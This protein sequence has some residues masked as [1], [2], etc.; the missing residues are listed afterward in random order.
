MGRFCNLPSV[1]FALKVG[2]LDVLTKNVHFGKENLPKV[3]KDTEN[4][5]GKPIPVT[6]AT[7]V[8]GSYSEWIPELPLSVLRTFTHPHGKLREGSLDGDYS[9]TR[10]FNEVL[11]ASM[12]DNDFSD[13]PLFDKVYRNFVP[14][15]QRVRTD[16][17][18]AGNNEGQIGRQRKEL[19]GRLKPTEEI[20]PDIR[21][22]VD[23]IKA[24]AL[25]RVLEKVHHSE[26]EVAKAIARKE[27]D[28]PGQRE[29]EDHFYTK[30]VKE[31]TCRLVAP[32]CEG[33]AAITCDDISDFSVG[34]G[35]R[36]IFF[37]SF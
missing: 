2:E 24:N 28:N 14:I 12:L 18:I 6:K 30:E 4:W 26:L 22:M 3:S 5:N 35:A 36:S 11:Q 25:T 27:G 21:V 10:R 13:Q 23:T 31:I 7:E 17:I 15:Q 9:K 1:V 32:K 33:G 19:L 16:A 8:L 37:C 34:T 29:N 20:G